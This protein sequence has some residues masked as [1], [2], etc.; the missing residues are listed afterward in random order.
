MHR[1]FIFESR[2][3]TDTK[4]P[5]KHLPDAV[6]DHE[7][8]AQHLQYVGEG[9]ERDVSVVVGGDHVDVGV[10]EQLVDHL[11]IGEMTGLWQ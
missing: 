6:D 7:H 3:E 11:V 2:L 9:Q 10:A 4:C 5:W 1:I 8:L